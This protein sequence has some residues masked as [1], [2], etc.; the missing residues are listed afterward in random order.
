[1]SFLLDETSQQK[2]VSQFLIN[3]FLMWKTCI[4]D[5]S[6]NLDWLTLK[7]SSNSEVIDRPIFRVNN[8]Q[9]Q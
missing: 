9:A 4:P 7:V 3:R 2:G 1:M 5:V 8:H 6:I